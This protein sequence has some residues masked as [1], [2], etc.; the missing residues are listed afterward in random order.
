[1]LIEG[2]RLGCVLGGKTL[3]RGLGFSCGKGKVVRLLGQNGSG[4][5]TFIRCLS[6]ET[7]YQGELTLFS[8]NAILFP[9]HEREICLPVVNQMPVLDVHLPAIDNL[10]DSFEL[11]DSIKKW[12]F[13]SRNKIR[14]QVAEKHHEL[15]EEFGLSELVFRPTYELSIGQRRLLTLIR[16]LRSPDSDAIKVVL[17]D[18]PLAGLQEENVNRVLKVLRKRLQQDWSF[19]I[20]EHVPAIERL[21]PVSLEFPAIDVEFDTTHC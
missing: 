9:S 20:A 12:L 3:F 2:K 17:L 11:G 21:N 1:M 15:L 8:R 18:E 10:I 16:A 14:R 19:I 6:G 5:T 7:H 4:K 13:C